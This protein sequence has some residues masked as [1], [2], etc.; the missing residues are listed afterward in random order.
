MKKIIVCIFALF[1]L[2][3]CNNVMNTPTKEV[4]EFLGKY[5]TMDSKVL[6]QLDDVIKTDD[7]I[8]KRM[9]TRVL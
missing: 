9:I 4:E 8:N 2:A 5:Q 1:T 7:M 6:S 3:G